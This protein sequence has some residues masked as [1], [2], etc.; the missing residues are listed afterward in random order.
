ML[1]NKLTAAEYLMQLDN[2]DGL[3]YVSNMIL[4]N[5]DLGFDFR[6]RFNS[7]SQ[8][9]KIEAIPLLLK[10]LKIAKQPRFQE[11]KYHSL[12]TMIFTSLYN[13]GIQSENNYLIIKDK[14]EVFIQENKG[15]I[16]HLNF[17]HSNIQKIEEQMYL[18]KSQSCKIEDAIEEFGKL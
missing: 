4:N 12:E 6:H 2:L 7:I 13:M 5:S 18:N 1:D 16:E 14:L 17:I 3:I 9:K 8:M 15:Q 11:D 10:L